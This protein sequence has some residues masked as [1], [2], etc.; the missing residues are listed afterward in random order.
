M[1][2]ILDFINNPNI[3]LLDQ[4]VQTMYF[5]SEPDRRK[6]QNLLTQLKEDPNSWTRAD[7]ILENTQSQQTKYF[8]LQILDQVIATRWKILPREQC[9]GIKSYVVSSVIKLTT[10]FDT[11][12][13]EK[14]LV[15]KLNL[16]LIEIVKQ[17]WP[18]QWESF[19]PDLCGSSKASESLCYNNMVILKL[20]TEEVFDFSR[21]QMVEAKV[22]YLR[23]RMNKEFASIYELIELVLTTSGNAKLIDITLETL[24]KYLDWVPFGYIF[25]TGLTRRLADI[26]EN[27][28]F[29]DNVLR[30]L[31]EIGGLELSAD[32]KPYEEEICYM[33]KQ[34]M[35]KLKS[36]LPLNIN[37][38]PLYNSGTQ[39]EQEFIQSLAIYLTTI[40]KTHY[41][42]LEK[43]GE[44]M[45][46]EVLDGHKYL[47]LISQIE[48]DE[49]FKIV[50]E[51]WEFLT[52]ALY[53]ENPFVPYT[54]GGLQLMASRR[55]DRYHNILSKARV[56]MISRM[57][58][59]EEVL[60]VENDNGEIVRE[61]MKDTDSITMYKNMRHVLVYLTH[62][63][64]AD[65][66]S[67]MTEKLQKQVDGSEWSWKN[68]NT[69]CWAIGS[70]SGCMSEDDEKR[71]LVT[72]IKELLGMCENKRGKDNKAVIA[73]NIMYIV[74]Q[75]PRF[76]RAH[77]KFLKTVVKKLFEFMH[78]THEGVQDMACDTFIKIAQ[79][80]KIQFVRQ[81]PGEQ[82]PFIVEILSEISAI[83]ND[84]QP[85]QIHTFYEAVGHM[86]AAQNDPTQREDLIRKYMELPNRGW[87]DIM[88]RARQNP[89]VLQDQETVRNLY[90]ILKTNI[91]AAY[92]V[93]H[94]YIVQLSDIYSDMLFIYSTVGQVIKQAI[95]SN[96]PNVAYTAEM[97]SLR[98][99]RKEV[100]RLVDTWVSKC[101]NS[102]RQMVVEQIMPQ[103]LETVLADY[104]ESPL[105]AREP[106]VL[107]CLSSI[108]N[109]LE[110]FIS[111]HAVAIYD[112]VFEV[113]LNMI[114]RE[115]AEFPE[116]RSEFY[117]L[118]S[119]MI[120]H[121]F[122][123]TLEGMN[124]EKMDLLIN[125]II[126]A[127]K[128]TMRNVADTG[129]QILMDLL[130]R[131][132]KSDV[133]Q[134]FYQTYYIKL[135]E[136]IL[137]VLTDSSYKSGFRMH[138]EGLQF[139][140]QICD[141]GEI[142]VPLYDQATTNGTYKN[143]QEYVKTYISQ[144]LAQHFPNLTQKQ[145]ETVV[146][147]MFTYCDDQLKFKNHLRDFLIQIKE[148]AGSGEGDLF[149][150]EKEKELQKEQDRKRQYQLSVPG[151]LN[152]HEREEM[153]DG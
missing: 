119:A 63:D 10:D 148:Y 153:M 15:N 135:L 75:Y 20:L 17:D 114:N 140:I 142:T 124:P 86:I 62:L 41:K 116:H 50:L 34:S 122:E 22:R 25:E 18:D 55:V 14:I 106:E 115:F 61:F 49:I 150:E 28:T 85:H 125:A 128:H 104:K 109:K 26:L 152:P 29:R 54:Q 78:E 103:F 91:R 102:E 151:L 138:A 117:V 101:N 7:Y 132:S 56:V 96:G 126:W 131:F 76:L 43:A 32:Q 137:A 40:L 73:S 144:I 90:L 133:A 107:S 84:L 58:K 82:Q 93:G 111:P 99:V 68:L 52:Q 23:D 130:D 9:E 98:S 79:K 27:P 39:K 141:R 123:A 37:L 108:I 74:G 110:K 60:I 38:A 6:A 97:K 118:L 143:N 36:M 35:V 113:T 89:A 71:F 5:G 47:I 121:C 51:Y 13:K 95:L 100:L 134:P 19:I 48:D 2:A 16:T 127:I 45:L 1:D 24:H 120:K 11:M 65:T 12:Q 81:Q 33:Y 92:A 83:I 94:P 57:A 42:T 8:A 70:I 64:Y 149:T 44:E 31:T 66:E 146:T 147:G 112:N 53:N 129:M 69:L 105:I 30:C 4:V 139:M 21:E 59:P 77:W 145:I 80:C 67:I 3:Q 88:D 72:V 46:A 136:H 87:R